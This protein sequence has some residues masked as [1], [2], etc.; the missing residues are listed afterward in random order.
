[1]PGELGVS[2]SFLLP[3]RVGA[4]GLIEASSAVHGIQTVFMD[5]GFRRSDGKP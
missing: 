5:S 1:M 3:P 2:P 4:R